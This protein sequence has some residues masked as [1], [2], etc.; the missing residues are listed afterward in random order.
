M[1]SSHFIEL[2]TH[3]AES[4]IYP[5]IYLGIYPTVNL[6]SYVVVIFY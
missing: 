6:K 4:D 1:L 5:I 2:P 3:F